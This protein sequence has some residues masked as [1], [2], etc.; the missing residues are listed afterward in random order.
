MLICSICQLKNRKLV[1]QNTY[2]IKCIDSILNMFCYHYITFDKVLVKQPKTFCLIFLYEADTIYFPL[3]LLNSTFH[4]LPEKS[5]DTLVCYHQKIL[6]LYLVLF[7]AQLSPSMT[8][9][10]LHPFLNNGAI[11]SRFSGALLCLFIFQYIFLCCLAYHGLI[12]FLLFSLSCNCI[13][14]LYG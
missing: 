12:F 3:W 1:N 11:E 10:F 9:T 7:V 2:C 13:A 14:K 8:H 5:Y 4:H 6:F